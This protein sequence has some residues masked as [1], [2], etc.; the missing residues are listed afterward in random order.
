M[1]RRPGCT[2]QPNAVPPVGNADAG[3]PGIEITI[4]E[5]TAREAH[6]SAIASDTSGLDLWA[7]NVAK[8]PNVHSNSGVRARKG[9]GDRRPTRLEVL[10]ESILEFP[11]LIR[12]IEG[13]IRL[14][15]K[16]WKYRIRQV[17]VGEM[18]GILRNIAARMGEGAIDVFGN[19]NNW[20]GN[21]VEAKAPGG[22]DTTHHK[23]DPWDTERLI[24]NE[25]VNIDALKLYAQKGVDRR[26][27]QLL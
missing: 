4:R 24:V 23:S 16:T 21:W 22:A 9:D 20:P 12:K 19:W 17:D 25:S 27:D 7:G 1:D 14:G 26:Q 11:Y 13:A 15:R 8:L 2:D 18:E 3:A 10:G 6:E 5:R